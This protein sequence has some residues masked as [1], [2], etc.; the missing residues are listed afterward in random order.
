M[1]QKKKPYVQ[2]VI[3]G[4][5][6][7]AAYV[8]LLTHQDVFTNLFTRGGMYAALPLVAVF[9]VSFVHGPFASNVLSLMGIEA[10]KKKK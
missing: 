6:S 1:S 9:F 7:I 3:L 5:I 4:I 8:Y 10:A 2:T